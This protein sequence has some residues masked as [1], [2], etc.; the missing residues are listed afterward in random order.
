MKA[1]RG[2]C[3]LLGLAALFAASGCTV[4]AG[5]AVYVPPPACPEGYYYSPGYGCVPAAGPIA[6]PGGP[7]YAVVNTDGL[8]LRACGSMKCGIINSLNAG[9]QVQVL[10][11]EDGWTHVWAFTRNQEGWVATRFLN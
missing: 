4:S 1:M 9:E 6:V 3:L 10:G 2:L 11:Q 8:S 7:V 5:P